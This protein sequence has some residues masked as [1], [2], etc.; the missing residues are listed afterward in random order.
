MN[1][2]PTLATV[3]NM[4]RYEETGSPI[5]AVAY[6]PMTGEEYSATS[7]DYFWLGEN[8]PLTDEFCNPM[9]LVSRTESYELIRL[10]N[11]GKWLAE[12]SAFC[13]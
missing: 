11:E 8:E 1:D 10:E 7:G 3:A 4:K 2:Q 6:S 9:I 5:H 13:D 12:Y